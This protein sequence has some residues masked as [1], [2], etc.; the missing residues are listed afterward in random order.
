MTC[1][2]S[3]IARKSGCR[4]REGNINQSICPPGREDRRHGRMFARP[5]KPHKEKCGEICEQRQFTDGQ[6][7]TCWWNPQEHEAE[8][9]DHVA[10]DDRKVERDQC[11][12]QAAGGRVRCRHERLS[13]A[14]RDKTGFALCISTVSPGNRLA[15]KALSSFK[16]IRCPPRNKVTERVMSSSSCCDAPIY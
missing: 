16:P 6:A 4:D 12:I 2:P 5:W 15:F 7:K 11:G 9:E 13:R 10:A 14:Y 3:E 1:A 8:V